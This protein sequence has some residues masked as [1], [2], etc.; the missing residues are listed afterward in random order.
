MSRAALACFFCHT[1]DDGVED[2]SPGLLF[3][4]T[5]DLPGLANLPAL[6]NL[7]GPLSLV[8]GSLGGFASSVG[9]IAPAPLLFEELPEED[10]KGGILFEDDFFETTGIGF[11]E[12]I[13]YLVR[14]LRMTL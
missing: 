6:S 10:F 1:E 13:H 5:P 4:N 12:D 3:V 14:G 7:E 11:R 2:W 9:D 8:Q